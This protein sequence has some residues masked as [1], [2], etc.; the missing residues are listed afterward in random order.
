MVAGTAVLSITGCQVSLV[1]KITVFAASSLINPLNTILSRY[2][3]SDFDTEFVVHYGGSNNLKSQIELGAPADVY[4]SADPRL[5]I[6]LTK[7]HIVSGIPSP[8]ASNY[9]AIL[10]PASSS[11][12]VHTI[13]DLTKHS[14]RIAMAGPNVPAGRLARDLLRNLSMENEFGSNFTSLVH[15]KVISH[16]TSAQG[17]VSKI[18]LGEVDAGFA[19]QSDSHNSK[20]LR[21]VSLPKPALVGTNYIAVAL[22]RENHA[23]QKFVDY[24]TTTAAKSEFRRNGFEAPY[25]PS[26][27]PSVLE[28]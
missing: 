21:A 12:V 3:Y 28:Q 7:E 19:F 5:I 9:A 26:S 17:V 16:E 4:I 11:S 1:N 6:A 10:A 15:E 25:P 24:L 13:H 2:Q 23:A 27:I 22:S 8:I 18:L 14:V 20:M